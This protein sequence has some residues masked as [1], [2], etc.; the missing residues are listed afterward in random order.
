MNISMPAQFLQ[1][2][3]QAAKANYMSRSNFI[4]VALL[5]KMGLQNMI[6]LKPLPPPGYERPPYYDSATKTYN[7]E[8]LDDELRRALGL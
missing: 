5:E 4:R 3:D 8:G 6:D 2:V 1:A 7:P